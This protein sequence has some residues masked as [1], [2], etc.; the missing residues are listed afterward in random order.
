METLI[1]KIVLYFYFSTENMLKNSEPGRARHG[2]ARHEIFEHIF[3]AKKLV[4]VMTHQILFSN[5]QTN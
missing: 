3:W 5:V 2:R 1:A 4:L